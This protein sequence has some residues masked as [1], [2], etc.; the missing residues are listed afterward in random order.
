MKLYAL[1]FAQGARVRF[2]GSPVR[3]PRRGRCPLGL[4]PAL[5]PAGL[6][7]VLLI[8]VPTVLFVI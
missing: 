3:L 6:P 8:A 2:P 4:G 5:L 1:A 7:L